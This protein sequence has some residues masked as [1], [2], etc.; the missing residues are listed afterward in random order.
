MLTD[1]QPDERQPQSEFFKARL[2]EKDELDWLEIRALAGIG[3]GLLLRHLGDPKALEKLA[4]L[5][6]PIDGLYQ[7]ATAK[8]GAML[9]ED[10]AGG[11]F[12]LT[13]QD[14]A[15]LAKLACYKPEEWE[16]LLAESKGLA[17]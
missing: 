12:D 16:R 10:A 9:I 1:P 8:A 7:N 13:E 11:P 6:V 3:A 15:D 14:W 17:K 2:C 4:R 5:A